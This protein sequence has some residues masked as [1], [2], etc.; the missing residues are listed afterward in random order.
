MP[1]GALGRDDRMRNGW[2]GLQLLTLLGVLP[3]VWAPSAFAAQGP[4]LADRPVKLT[5]DIAWTVPAASAASVQASPVELELSDGRVVDVTPWPSGVEPRREGE[6]L[7]RLGF[8]PA[9]RVRTRVDAPVGSSLVLRAG[10]QSMRFPLALVLEGPQHTPPQAPVEFSVERLA[11][12]AIEVSGGV[13]S[14]G[15][16][17]PGASVPLSLGFNVLTAE[18]T[19]VVVRCQAELKPIR[20]G[21]SVWS[22][23]IRESIATNTP[24]PAFR[25]VPVNLPK[26]EGTYLLELHASWEQVSAADP[27]AGT[28]IGRW[29][30]GR[31]RRGL[32]GASG[33]STRRLTMVVVGPRETGPAAK[34]AGRDQ[35]ADSV[36]LA[37][38]RG[39]RLTAAG[40]SA[41]PAPGRGAW[42]I[43]DGALAESTRRDRLRGWMTRVGS[44]VSQLAPA[45]SNGLAWS[46]VGLKVAHPGRPHRLSLTVTGGHPSALGVAVVGPGARPRLLLD[47]CASGPPILAE[48][49]PASFSWL[50]WPDSADPVLLMVNRGPA[51]AVQVGAV[52][53]TELADLPEP[54]AVDAPTPAGLARG[55]ALA[56]TGPDSLDRFGGGLPAEPHL[57][58]AL[59][60]S[61][62]LARYAASSGASSVLLSQGL[63][64]RDRRRALEG[65]AAE[66]SIGPD[67]L[68]LAL[69]ILARQGLSAWVELDLDGKLPGLPEPG[70]V[71]AQ[72]QGLVRLD[73]RGI[74]EG[75]SPA[76][77][78]LSPEVG[79]AVTR[80]AVETLAAYLGPAKADGPADPNAPLEAAGGGAAPAGLVIRLGRGPALPGAPDTGF[81]DA[82][83]PR[84]A[85]EA[86][87]AETARGLPGLA[88][89]DPE[90]FAARSKFLSGPGRMPWLTWRSRRVAALYS[91][92]AKA[93]K[94]KS[95]AGAEPTALAVVTPGLDDGP[96]GAEARRADLAG[97]GPSLAWRAVGLDLDLWPQGGDAPVVFRGVGLSPDDLAHDLATSPELDAKVAARPLRGLWLDVEDAPAAPTATPA[98][99]AAPTLSALPLDSGPSGEEPLGHALAAL[100]ARWVVLSAPAAAGH[101]ER[102]RRFARVF[103]GVPATPGPTAAEAPPL[104]FGVSVRVHKGAGKTFLAMANDTPYP[105]RLAAVVSAPADALF[106]D[107][108]RAARL[109]PEADAAGRHLVLDLPPFGVAG[110]KIGSA[111]AKVASVIPYPSDAVLTSLQARYD[112]LSARLT[113]L[114]GKPGE[115]D[116]A[117]GPD[118]TGPPNPGFEPQAQADRAVALAVGNA[119]PKGWQVVGPVNAVVADPAKPRSGLGSLRL[120]VTQPPGSAQSDSFRT[121]VQSVLLVRVWLR[122]DRPDARARL[123][124]EGESA[125]RPY[126]RVS[127][128]AVPMTWDERAVRASDLPS[129]GLDSMRLR[130]EMLTPGTLWVDDL[131]LSGPTLSDPERR[132]ARNALVAAIQ[133]YREKRYADF[134]RLAGSHWARLPAADA[135]RRGEGPLDRA[136]MI[137]TGDA[138]ALPQGRRLR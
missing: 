30:R 124:I 106:D 31:G 25:S 12:D 63:A 81:D 138:S 109:K 50:V 37:R 78:A 24:A 83:Y 65:Q 76:Y 40:R 8:G 74:P 95:P 1:R 64:D 10:G 23:E 42:T 41:A 49:G 125:G 44:E 46:A 111:D 119:P 94:A 34:S 123:W 105:V 39:N 118:R 122:T 131:A 90:R 55:I 7:W 60:A 52:T 128:L 114:N 133:A 45:D 32:A 102:L 6:R 20:G 107:L 98:R 121:G 9:G 29:I 75:P 43:P 66:D 36:D 18:P 73:R 100:D 2:R 33:T 93:L 17:A 85:R 58:D 22:T 57:L 86:F 117:A 67:R 48:A 113:R 4:G 71:E 56:V 38:F 108:G 135:A 116:A 110:V 11:W 68:G 99:P 3:G 26:A 112:E 53:L 62:N 61:R 84:F 28:M 126:R 132:N 127:D 15:T 14:G 137:R 5:L 80:K 69:R 129:G 103:R 70:S 82:T 19:G 77:Q 97:L 96:A 21:A 130:F 35:E 54:P 27:A 115:A 101:E 51:T 13:E 136:G 120:D 79:E 72:G 91:G 88:A 134:A 47:A 16:F 87:D 92:L 89:D 59:A 104:P